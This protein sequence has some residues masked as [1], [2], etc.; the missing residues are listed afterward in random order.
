MGEDWNRDQVTIGRVTEGRLVLHLDNF[1]TGRSPYYDQEYVT[2]RHN[3]APT[4]FNDPM[5]AAQIL[6]QFGITVEGELSLDSWVDGTFDKGLRTFQNA[7]ISVNDLEYVVYG[8]TLLEL[9]PVAH[10]GDGIV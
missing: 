7:A 1:E 6:E 4:P 2:N 5:A 3:I 10:D 9:V 8:N